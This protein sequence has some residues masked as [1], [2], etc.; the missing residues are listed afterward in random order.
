[1]D[2]PGTNAIIRR[3]EELTRDFVPARRPGPV[4]HL[5]RPA[6]HRERARLPRADPRVGQEDRVRGQQDRHP[7][8][9]RGAWSRCSS[10]VRRA[11]RRRCWARRRG[12]SR[13]RRGW[14]AA[15]RGAARTRAGRRAGST[16]WRSICCGRWTRRSAIRLKLLNPLNVG[17]RLAAT[18]QGRGVRAAEA[19]GRGRRDDPGAS[20]AS[21]AAVHDEMLRDFEPRLARLE[22]LLGD[23]ERAG[24]AVLRGDRADRP[25]PQPDGQRGV[26]R[27][28]EREVIGDTPAADRGRGGRDDRL[29]GR[30]Q[31]E[32]CGRT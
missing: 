20:T 11:R 6:V 17:L 32:G 5:R 14:R 29:D 21:S 24:H 10:F 28:F 25:H 26:R 1:M 2:T 3:H 13:C 12:S 4:R 8:P 23:M 19:A 15:R 31:P 16:R 22:V 7:R 27:A 18:L 9:G 30:A